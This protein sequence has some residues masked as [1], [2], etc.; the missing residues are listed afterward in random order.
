LSERAAGEWLLRFV[1]DVTPPTAAQTE[2]LRRRL[3]LLLGAGNG[4]AV[5]QTDLLVPESSGKF[6]LGYPAKR[7]A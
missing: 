5:Q 1:A 3:A 2:E 7:N 4:L 6:R